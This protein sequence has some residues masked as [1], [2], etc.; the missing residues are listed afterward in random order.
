[1]KKFCTQS[2]AGRARCLEHANLPIEMVSSWVI[3]ILQS[4]TFILII[5]TRC[6]PWGVLLTPLPLNICLKESH[7]QLINWL[8]LACLLLRQGLQFFL[9]IT[10]VLHVKHVCHYIIIVWVFF[11]CAARFRFHGVMLECVLP[12][13]LGTLKTTGIILSITC[14]G[15]YLPA[16]LEHLRVFVE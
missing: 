7:V 5:T 13:L 16:V 10:C 12:V 6:L 1:M 9:L 14:I 8:I 2:T 11:L 4:K 3:C 15:D